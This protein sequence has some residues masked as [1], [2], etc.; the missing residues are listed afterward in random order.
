MKKILAMLKNYTYGIIFAIDLAF[1]E[2]RQSRRFIRAYISSVILIYI[3]ISSHKAV[4]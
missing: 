4:L 2:R 3:Q 1:K